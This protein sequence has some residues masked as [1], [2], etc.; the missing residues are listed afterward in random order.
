MKIYDLF[1]YIE[2]GRIITS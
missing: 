1:F 2:I